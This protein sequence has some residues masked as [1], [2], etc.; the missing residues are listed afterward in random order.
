MG[1]TAAAAAVPPGTGRVTTRRPSG[2]D[3]VSTRWSPGT[4]L[5]TTR[6]SSGTG[7]GS[8]RGCAPVAGPGPP[9]TAKA[10]TPGA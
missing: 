6:R 7:P 10:R 2:T 3:S 8:V 5:D 1:D 9:R 4:G